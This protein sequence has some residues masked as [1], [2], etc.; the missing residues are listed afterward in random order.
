MT[1][2]PSILAL[3]LALPLPLA[4]DRA[5]GVAVDQ[6]LATVEGVAILRSEVDRRVAELGE[7]V[8][9]AIVLRQL[10]LSTLLE[11]KA[12]EAGVEVEDSRLDEVMAERVEALGG[13]EAYRDHLDALE[14]DF[15]T[16]RVRVR[17]ALLVD[18]YV[19]HALGIVRGSP[20]LRPHLARRVHVTPREVQAHYRAHR[21]R[22]RVDGRTEV[23]RLVV[24]KA[25]FADESAARA[26]AEELRANAERGPGGLREAVAEDPR[27]RYAEV[28]LSP[29]QRAA[30]RR[31]LLRALERTP[32]GSPSEIVETASSFLL[33]VKRAEE[34]AR[35]LSFAEAQPIVFDFLTESKV[36]E[37]RVELSRELVAEAEIWP[38]GLFPQDL[39]NDEQAVAPAPPPP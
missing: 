16:D 18:E 3:L 21:E 38:E 25:A 20:H 33:L 24:P 30:L 34:P 7:R 14:L 31:D 5:D 26:R 9:E 12:K 13:P 35:T 23:G 37:A 1:G 27:V 2:A 15:E 8:E 11:A 10:V 36:R 32:V 19:R 22:Y 28:T 29:D 4:D 17:D 39:P 6:V